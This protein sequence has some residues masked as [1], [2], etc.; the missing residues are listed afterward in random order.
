MKT[1]SA[2]MPICSKNTE[3]KNFYMWIFQIDTEMLDRHELMVTAP[4]TKEE[5]RNKIGRKHI[6]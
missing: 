5:L 4:A 2:H 6:F 3:Q 1:L